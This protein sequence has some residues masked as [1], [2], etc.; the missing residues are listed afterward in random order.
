VRSREERLRVRREDGFLL[1]EVV[2]AGGQDRPFR[3][4]LVPE[5]SDVRLGEGPFPHEA[6]AG[7]EP[8]AVAEALAFGDL[9]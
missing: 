5:A 8:R 2:D 3:R 4:G 6:L 1:A 7:D 9:G